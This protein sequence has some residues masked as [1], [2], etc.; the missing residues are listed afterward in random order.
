MNSVNPP[1][2]TG[3]FTTLD[4]WLPWLETLSPREIVLG[5]ERVREVLDCLDL[6]QPNLVLN[7][8]GTNGKGSTVA[9]LE[10]IL[11]SNG[12]KTG[13]YTS[14]HLSHFNERIRI[15][16]ESASDGEI[17][18]A[19]ERVEVARGDVP[20]TYFEFGTL[21]A[22]VAFDAAEVDTLILE[23][24]MG[25]RL[26]AV[27]A[28]E[29][30]ACLITNV[31]LDHCAWLGDDTESIGAEKAGIM[32]AGK[33]VVFGAKSVPRAIKAHAEKIGA[34]LLLAG[35]DFDVEL[36]DRT[37]G[38]SWRGQS[39]EL[40][41]L[42]LPALRGEVQLQ[43]AAAVLSLLEALGLDQLLNRKTIDS[44]FA[45]LRLP[46]RFQVLDYDKKWILDV[47]HNAGSALALSAAIAGIPELAGAGKT[48]AVVGMLADKDVEGIVMLLR[49]QV[50]LWVAVT[51]AGNRAEKAATLAR[52]IANC[53]NKP[54]LVAADI[55]SALEYADM[56]TTHVDAVL[57][58]GS[59][60]LIGP[61]LQWLRKT[62]NNAAN[63]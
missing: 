4:D 62:Q 12:A 55:S 48:I 50:D 40:T 52:T 49:D 31:S 38:W 28:V 33:P 14:P 53:C 21:A 45:S 47:A 54:C 18:N 44:A 36:P 15:D 19:L 9:M 58:A 1:N 8:A 42:A 11:R 30:D 23:V 7:I 27:N 13:C 63:L 61:T 57:V 26:D 32:R 51:V 56:H 59:F 6:P 3:S 39:H 5:L 37:S 20:L 46:G 22:L 43:N 17:I 35:V 29:P 10:A 2:P 24:G 41:D 25:G 34:G 16:G 60:Y